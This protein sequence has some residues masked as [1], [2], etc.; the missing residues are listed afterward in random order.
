M[1]YQLVSDLRHTHDITILLISHDLDLVARHAN[2]VVILDKTI[3][4]EGLPQ[5]VYNTTAFRNIF[6]EQGACYL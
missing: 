2:K 3:V 6:G 1:F 5:D 4:A